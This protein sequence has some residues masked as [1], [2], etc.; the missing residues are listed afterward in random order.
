MTINELLLEL[1]TLVDLGEE[2]SQIIIMENDGNYFSPMCDFSIMS[3]IPESTWN[4][5]VRFRHLNDELIK[6]GYTDE[7]VCEDGEPVIV[8]EPIH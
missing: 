3:Y 1:K 5:Y 2:E 8:F 4:G 7:D 6:Q